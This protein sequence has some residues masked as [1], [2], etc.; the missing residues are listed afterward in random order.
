[1]VVRVSLHAKPGYFRRY[2]QP[3]LRVSNYSGYSVTIPCRNVLIYL[4]SEM[5]SPAGNE[6]CCGVAMQLQKEHGDGQIPTG[7]LYE[8]VFEHV[9]MTVGDMKSILVRFVRDE[10]PT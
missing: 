8:S 2:S 6:L 4:M 10:L 1:M 3:G 9:N 5:V 7:M